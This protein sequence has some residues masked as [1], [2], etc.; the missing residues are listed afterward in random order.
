[1]TNRG[2]S[3]DLYLREVGPDVYSTGLE[4]REGKPASGERLAVLLIESNTGP[5]QFARVECEELT[6]CT[7]QN[8]GTLQHV[9]I[10]QDIPDEPQRQSPQ[11]VQLRNLTASNC[12]VLDIAYTSPTEQDYKRCPKLPLERVGSELT[13]SKLQGVVFKV[14]EQRF[15]QPVMVMLLRCGIMQQSVAVLLGFIDEYDFGFCA[16]MS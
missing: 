13:R 10:R 2:L 8:R 15:R 3:T 14:P 7:M 16:L 4:C 9:S 1:M 11:F 5:N 12:Y 6:M